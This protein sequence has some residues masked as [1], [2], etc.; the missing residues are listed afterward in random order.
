MSFST[1]SSRTLVRV[2]PSVWETNRACTRAPVPRASAKAISAARRGAND[3]EEIRGLQTGSPDEGAVNIGNGQDVAGIIRLYRPA[4]ENAH[5]LALRAEALAQYRANSLM[6]L[7]NIRQ[8]RNLL[9]TAAAL[10]GDEG[11]IRLGHFG[12]EFCQATDAAHLAHTAPQGRN[13]V[14]PLRTA[15][16]DALMHE[17]ERMHWNISRTASMLGVSRNTLYRKIRKHQIVLPD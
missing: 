10:C 9:R 15:E 8:L 7:R 17:L 11:R 1:L 2:R 14:D 12:R 6:H 3:A 16:R 5:L 13:E 4:I